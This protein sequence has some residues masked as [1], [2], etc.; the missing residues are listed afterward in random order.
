MWWRMWHSGASGCPS[1]VFFYA[2]LQS[3]IDICSFSAK[4]GSAQSSDVDS[5]V[6]SLFGA[7]GLVK[8]A[9]TLRPPKTGKHDQRCESLLQ[10]L[11]EY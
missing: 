7:L 3:C 8:K 2:S 11:I 1:A 4:A 9:S 5:D 6:P 10:P